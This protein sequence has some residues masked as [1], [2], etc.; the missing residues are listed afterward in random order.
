MPELPTTSRGAATSRRILDAAAEEFAERGIAGARIDRIIGA[1]HTNK[2]QLYGYFGSKDGLFDAVIA[3]RADRLISA[4]PFDANDLPGWAVGVYDENLRHPDLVR[5]VAWLRLERRPSGRL[6]DSPG[7][8]PK[9][10]A[11][12][13]AQAAGQVRPGDPSDLFA[14][15]LGMAFAWSPAS[16]FYAATADEPAA[17]HD[18][19]RALLRDSV[20]RVAAS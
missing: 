7:N 19:R 13:R 9:F 20:A 18:R 8:E 10:E 17:D 11:I 12:A 16:G 6:S 5:L 15:I 4:V 2:A 14:V 1:A 3:D